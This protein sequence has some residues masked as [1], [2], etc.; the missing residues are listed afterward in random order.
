MKDKQIKARL[1][2]S[3]SVYNNLINKYKCDIYNLKLKNITPKLVVINIGNNKASLSYIKKKK[4]ACESIG[5]CFNIINLPED[6]SI[7]KLEQIISEIN[8]DINIHGLFI[9]LPL[10]VHFN[11]VNIV[12]M[13]NY[14]KD[15]DGFSAY[16]LGRL[17]QRSPNII[18]CTALGIVNLLDEYKI[19]IKGENIVVIGDSFVVGRPVS[20]LL[21]N[22][23]ATVTICH[24]ETQG[25]GDKIDKAKII[26]T[27]IGQNGVIKTAWLNENHIIIDVGINYVNGKLCGDI[28]FDSAKHIVSAITPVPGGTGP[29]TV[30]ALVGNLIKITCQQ[31]IQ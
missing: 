10:P 6:T 16:N 23:G 20:M 2:Q 12:S 22:K 19:N 28:D 14:S 8:H 3:K 24:K 29:M 25:L 4:E 21:L 15:V 30:A 11:P 17:C 7:I 13:I 1:I 5:I 18:S 27:A 31:N 26:I 9:Q